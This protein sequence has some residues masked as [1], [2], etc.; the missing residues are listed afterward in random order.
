MSHAGFQKTPKPTAAQK[1][2]AAKWIAGVRELPCCICGFGPPVT[3]HHCNY[4][5]FSGKKRPDDKTIPLC[6]PCHKKLH[7]GK[8]SFFA[9]HGPD[10][11]YLAPTADALAGELTK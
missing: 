6:D 7:A 9:I 2:Y 3:A 10:I 8:E 4:E 5:R 11:D 1:R